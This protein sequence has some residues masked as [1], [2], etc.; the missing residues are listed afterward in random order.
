M[1]NRKLMWVVLLLLALVAASMVAPA[2]AVASPDSAADAA[3][4]VKGPPPQPG[5]PPPG[6]E[7][8]PGRPNGGRK[9]CRGNPATIFCSWAVYNPYKSGSDAVGKAYTEGHC[10]GCWHPLYISA[11]MWLW[12]WVGDHWVLVAHKYSATYA[13]SATVWAWKAYHNA[14]SSYYAATSHHYVGYD[15]T[16]CVNK[17]ETS[18]TVW[19]DF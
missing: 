6:R 1:S 2:G 14:Q 8:K 18:Q 15:S 11:E 10:A 19:L 9:V 3:H 17:D 5:D 7:G 13:Y 12:R 16:I 4:A